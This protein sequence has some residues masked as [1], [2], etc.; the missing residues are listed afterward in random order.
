M[1]L[2]IVDG[3]L[4]LKNLFRVIVRNGQIESFLER[5]Y[6]FNLIQGIGLEVISEG[7]AGGDIGFIDSQLFA[8]D[9]TNLFDDVLLCGDWHKHV[10]PNELKGT[11]SVMARANWCKGE[12]RKTDAERGGLKQLPKENPN[13]L[14]LLWS[15]AACTKHH[16]PAY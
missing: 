8:D 5:H 2:D 4:Y 10:P 15:N 7:C 11:I 1:F 13:Y 12:S 14:P 9:L 16:C 6:E 3:I